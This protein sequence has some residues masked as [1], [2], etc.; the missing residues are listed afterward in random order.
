MTDATPHR[1]PLPAWVNLDRLVSAEELDEMENALAELA[2]L[3][4]PIR[5][6]AIR[7]YRAMSPYER[8]CDGDQAGYLR[9]MLAE[10]TP[11][12]AIFTLLG[13]LT[14]DLGA[15]IDSV[16]ARPDWLEEEEARRAQ[17]LRGRTQ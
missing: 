2:A 1:G 9:D 11:F 14:G 12:D 10:V 5:L 15:V 6:A 13:D 7:A 3:A 4:E 16:T 17:V 8:A